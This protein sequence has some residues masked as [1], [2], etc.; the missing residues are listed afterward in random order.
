MTTLSEGRVG[1]PSRPIIPALEPIW[2]RLNAAADVLLRVAVGGL[3]LPHGITRLLSGGIPKTAAFMEKMGLE[4]A[5]ALSIY[6]T[7]VEV[8][9]GTML[10]IGLLTRPVAA[11][12]LGF[13]AVAVWI[14]SH[15]GYFWTNT[16]SEMPLLWALLAFVVLI[17]GGGRYSVD[18]LIGREI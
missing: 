11:L 17:K 15:F 10:V 4:P 6:V 3:M 18:H 1:S 7:G 14:H 8:I 9:G 5:Y 2:A 12:T 16:G 13:M